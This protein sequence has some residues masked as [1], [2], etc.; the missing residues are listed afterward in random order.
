LALRY[1]N[2]L[3]MLRLLSLGKMTQVS[4]ACELFQ[5]VLMVIYET[6]A[7]NSISFGFTAFGWLFHGS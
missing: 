2:P 5:R 4:V 1:K 3:E 6:S 7:I